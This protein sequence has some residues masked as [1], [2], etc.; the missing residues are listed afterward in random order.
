M[1]GPLPTSGL[2]THRQPCQ[3]NTQS[4]QQATAQGR[5]TE[6]QP[7]LGRAIGEVCQQE[8]SDHLV[9]LLRQPGPGPPLSDIVTARQVTWHDNDNAAFDTNTGALSSQLAT[10]GT[11]LGGSPGEETN[12]LGTEPG[13]KLQRGNKSSKSYKRMEPGG[14]ELGLIATVVLTAPELGRWVGG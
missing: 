7:L 12:W 4:V 13:R 2:A 3:F 5:S 8:R 6:R 1:T 10:A 14:L 11:V 9:H